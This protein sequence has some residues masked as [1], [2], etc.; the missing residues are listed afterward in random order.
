MAKFKVALERTDMVTKQA[1]IMVEAETTEEARQIIL[2]DLEI[3][4]G[5]Y[6]DD[7]EPIAEGTG[8]HDGNN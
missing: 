4:L 3:D 7:L 6:Y 1:E 8:G 2:A 5:S